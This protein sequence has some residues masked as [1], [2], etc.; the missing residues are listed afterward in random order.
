MHKI[1]SASVAYPHSSMRS[2]RP[3]RSGTAAATL[4]Q[5]A[6]AVAVL[7]VALSAPAQAQAPALPAPETVTLD[8]LGYM[9]T[10]P[11]EGAQRV[12]LSNSY[13]YPQLRW[14]VQHLREQRIG[15]GAVLHGH[16]VSTNFESNRPLALIW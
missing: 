5:T 8:K 2:A 10:F 1:H 7:G 15:V 12:D 3:R 6:C 11:P 13:K 16:S 14:A 9:S 4:W